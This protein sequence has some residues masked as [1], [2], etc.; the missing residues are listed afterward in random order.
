MRWVCDDYRIG[1]PYL[2]GNMSGWSTYLAEHRSGTRVWGA[3][4]AI[5]IHSLHRVSEDDWQKAQALLLAGKQI[6]IH[7]A[8]KQD[9]EMLFAHGDYRRCT[10]DLCIAAETFLRQ[11]VW[12]SLPSNLDDDVRDYIEQA[13]ANR[14]IDKFFPSLL[15]VT[16]RS[17]YGSNLR[18][19]LK[20]LF[21]VRNK[22]M[23]VGS[24]GLASR[25]SC[26]IHLAAV[27]SLFALAPTPPSI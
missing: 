14:Y 24:R 15:D 17:L 27:R 9:A 26:S 1:R 13:N 23:H 3:S 19:Q 5:V 16:Q 7:L 20:E 10:I 6:P 8:Q 11:A 22:I 12:Q 21:R 4:T 25:D 18:P 2:V